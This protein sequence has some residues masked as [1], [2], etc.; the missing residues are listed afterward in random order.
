M[1]VVCGRCFETEMTSAPRLCCYYLVRVRRVLPVVFVVR[2]WMVGVK[3]VSNVRALSLPSY[4][5][6]FVL[7]LVLIILELK[8]GK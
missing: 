1:C 8:K 3:I 4:P 5:P 6:S 7:C 2:P